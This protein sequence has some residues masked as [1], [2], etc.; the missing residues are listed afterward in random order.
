M[1]DLIIALDFNNPQAALDMAHLLSKEVRWFKIG[2]ELFIAS[3]P[4]LLCRLRQELPDAHIFLDLKIYDIPNTA[5]KAAVACAEIGAEMLTLHCQGGAAMCQAVLK[6]L[7]ASSVKPP[8]ALGVTCL[9]SFQDGDMPGI[10]LPIAIYASQL[11]NLAFQ[12]GLGGVVCSAQEAATIKAIHPALKCICPGI[13]PANSQQG[14]Q[15]RI[16][17]PAAA[18]AAG[19]DYIVIGRPVILSQDPLMAVETIRAEMELGAKSQV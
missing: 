6:A 17:T 11:A 2:L 13:R 10:E 19:A 5:A 12:W 9:T 4:D 16:T 3:G 15:K 7:S 14:D 8:L 18:V 1:T